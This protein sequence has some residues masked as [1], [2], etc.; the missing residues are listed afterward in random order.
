MRVVRS[1]EWEKRGSFSLHLLRGKFFIVN[2]ILD[3]IQTMVHAA[4]PMGVLINVMSAL[5]VFHPNVHSILARRDLYQSKQVRDKQT[6]CIL[7]K[8]PTMAS[9][10]QSGNH[11]LSIWFVPISLV[12]GLVS[13]VCI[14]LPF[15]FYQ[16]WIPISAI[17]W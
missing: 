8:T 2:V 10:T 13:S 15:K 9:T 5:S 1:R 14:G 17:L 12:V 7:G 16:F 6:A 4:H 11:A 3:I